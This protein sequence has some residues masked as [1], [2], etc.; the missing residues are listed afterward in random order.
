MKRSIILL[1][2]FLLM[3]I[4]ACCWC[5]AGQYCYED[6]GSY[7]CRSYGGSLRVIQRTTMVMSNV[8]CNQM[9]APICDY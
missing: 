7:Q 9:D 6:G 5:P 2:F 8:S 1:I 3:F 4:S